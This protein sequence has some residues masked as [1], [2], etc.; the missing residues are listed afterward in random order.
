V[1]LHHDAKRLGWRLE[2]DALEDLDDEVHRRVI[3]VQ[4][5]DLEE[6]RLLRLIAR[7]LEDFLAELRT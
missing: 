3:V 2:K 1:N 5:D 6:R 7:P 4:Q